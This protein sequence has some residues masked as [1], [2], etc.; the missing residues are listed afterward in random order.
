M[1]TSLIRVDPSHQVNRRY[2]VGVQPTLWDPWAVVCIWGSRQTR[3]QRLRVMPVTSRQAGRDLAGRIVAQKERRG[4][5]KL[6]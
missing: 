5:Q 3:Y 6:P 4:Y 1:G 2:W